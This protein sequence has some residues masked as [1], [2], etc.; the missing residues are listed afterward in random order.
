M[1]QKHNIGEIIAGSFRENIKPGLVLQTLALAMLLLYYFFPPARAGFDVI[2]V[3]KEQGGFVFSSLSTG[4]FGGFLPYLLILGSGKI[5]QDK[6][7][8]L[9]LF[10]FLFWL[11]KGIEVDLLYRGQAILYGDSNHWLVVVKKVLTDQFIYCPLWAVPTMT[12]FYLWKDSGFG[13]SEVKDRL[14]EVSFFQRWLRVLV[15]NTVVWVPAVSIIY[16]LPLSLQ[17]PLFNLVLVFWTLI[18]NSVSEK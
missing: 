15:S 13:I 16:L 6:R 8:K 17:I 1:S 14:K 18:L 10:Y 7:L 12:L 4:F 2:G 5:P 11:W 9:F 3:W